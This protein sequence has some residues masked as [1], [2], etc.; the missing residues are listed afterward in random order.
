VYKS[1]EAKTVGAGRVSTQS[2][3]VS[4]RKLDRHENKNI[5]EQKRDTKRTAER[6]LKI[7][8]NRS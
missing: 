8:R 7:F 6:L 5:Q 4:S 2:T 3:M 1:A